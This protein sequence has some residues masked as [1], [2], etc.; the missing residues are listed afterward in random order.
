MHVKYIS[1]KYI[2]IYCSAILNVENLVGIDKGI[3]E[4]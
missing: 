3:N 4:I 2:Y 1:S